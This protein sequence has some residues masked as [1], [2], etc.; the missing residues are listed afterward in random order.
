MKNLKNP[1]KL[2]QT[3]KLCALIFG[4]TSVVQAQEYDMTGKVNSVSKHNVQT[5]ADGHMVLFATMEEPVVA[6]D[7]ADTPWKGGAG[8]CGGVVEI[9]GKAMKGN[10]V[11]TFTDADKEKFVLA[12]EAQ[13]MNEK[14]EPKGAWKIT[15][16]TGKYAKAEARGSY[17]N[18][19]NEPNSPNSTVH[20]T[21][22]MLIP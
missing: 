14:G 11:C 13:E 19:P 7:Y 22:K 10:G 4:M 18:L 21:G 8:I 16:G 2:F 1:Q 15:G 9:K 17:T 20:L 3:L 6:E 12:W 5:I